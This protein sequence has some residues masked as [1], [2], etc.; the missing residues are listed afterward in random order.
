MRFNLLI[1]GLLLSG[2]VHANQSKKMN[3]KN[4]ELATLGTGCFWCTEAIFQELEGVAKVESGYMGGQ[5]EN[6]TYKDICTGL[7]GHAEVCQITFDPEVISFASLL[8]VFWQVHNPTT[9]N[10]QGAD[11]GTQYRSVIFYNNEEQKKIANELLIKLDKSEAYSDPIVTEI[12]EAEKFYKAENYHQDYY[13]LN[14]SQPYCN[15]VI[16]P[17]QDKFKK[18]FKDRLKK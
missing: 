16:K 1:I 14:K 17:K 12:S 3:Q 4:K 2:I 13:D 18:V 5:T 6:P 8:E 7:T 10:K 9:L 11:V 15:L